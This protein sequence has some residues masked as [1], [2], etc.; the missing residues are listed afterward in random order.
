MKIGIITIQ[1]SEVNYGACLQSYALWKYVNNLGYD[2]EVIDLSRPCHSDYVVSPSFGEA[3]LSFK[4]RLRSLFL[5]VYYI[6]SQPSMTRISKQKYHNFNDKLIYS[7]RYKSV[8]RLYRYPP[9]YDIAITGSD[10]VWN[11]N[12]PFINEPYFLTFLQNCRKISYASSFGITS[13]PEGVIKDYQK[14]LSCYSHISTRE[15]SGAS[16]IES[17]IGKQ[18]HVVVDPVFLLTSDQWRENQISCGGLTSTKYIF[19]YMLHYDKRLLFHAEK[20]A[21]LKGLPL[22]FV[23]SENL[24]IE[25][26]SAVQLV[27]IGPGEW[28]WLINNSAITVTN[29][30]HGSAFSVLF[31]RPLAVFLDKA[32]PTNTRIEGFFSMLGMNKHLFDIDSSIDYSQIDFQITS[33]TKLLLE[34]ERGKSIRYLNEAISND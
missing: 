24:V 10:Q 31:D 12:M 17:L 32:N 23:L 26:S 20:I 28:M 1:K 16:I 6:F 25:T 19:L 22:Y 7:T 2:C 21:E 9:T 13:L 4:H 18:P 11:P 30:F 14:W 34:A 15:Q 29:S 33:Q 8:E 27:D 3:K 5:K